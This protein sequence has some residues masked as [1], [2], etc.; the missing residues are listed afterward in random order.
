M[1]PMELS[2]WGTLM[3]SILFGVVL[4]ALFCSGGWH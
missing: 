1:T 4:F 3:V 2:N